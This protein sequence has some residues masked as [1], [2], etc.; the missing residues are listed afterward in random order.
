MIDLSKL[1]ELAK[2]ATPGR[3][4]AANI[5]ATENRIVHTWQIAAAEDGPLICTLDN[6]SFEPANQAFIAAANPFAIL[7]LCDRLEQV[8]D[9]LRR[10]VPLAETA[11]AFLCEYCPGNDLTISKIDAATNYARE[12]LSQINPGAGK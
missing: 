3:W 10:L 6:D 1:R 11:N 4:V 2:A 7:E 8:E 12:A 9:A 5:V